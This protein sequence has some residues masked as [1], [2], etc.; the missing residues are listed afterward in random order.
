M[1]IA[2]LVLLFTFGNAFVFDINVCNQGLSQST[3]ILTDI[4]QCTEMQTET[5]VSECAYQELCEKKNMGYIMMF[6]FVS[7]ISGAQ[8]HEACETQLRT[9]CDVTPTDRPGICTTFGGFPGFC[10]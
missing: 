2:V 6:C 7:E 8:N 5:E 9:L 3:Q 4:C 10:L 1:I